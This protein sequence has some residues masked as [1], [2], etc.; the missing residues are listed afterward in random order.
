MPEH[1]SVPDSPL[2]MHPLS[3]DLSTQHLSCERNTEMY[4]SI[5]LLW[6]PQLCVVLTLTVPLWR[7]SHIRDRPHRWVQN[8]LHRNQ[9]PPTNQWRTAEIGRMHGNTIMTV[10]KFYHT[11]VPAM[12]EANRFLFGFN[13]SLTGSNRSQ[14]Q[15]PHWTR[16]RQP[17]IVESRSY[18]YR[19]CYNFFYDDIIH[20]LHVRHVMWSWL[21][22]CK[23]FIGA[24][25]DSD[26]EHD[27]SRDRDKFRR[28]RND[29][30]SGEKGRSGRNDSY[31]DRPRQPWRDD[32][33]RSRE[34]YDGD[35]RKRHSSG[36]GR[37]RDWS[38]PQKR[39]RRQEW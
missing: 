24:M 30:G 7:I 16:S 33:R 8:A 13:H 19:S 22:T 3:P 37:G 34:E 36:Y 4:T 35:S 26:D 9:S 17:L 14:S 31:R 39:P 12:T 25:G 11:N 21:R 28:E 20:C 10:L 29:Y 23:N 15:H 27:R 2:C 38:P 18:R 5:S 32:R 1:P 6:K